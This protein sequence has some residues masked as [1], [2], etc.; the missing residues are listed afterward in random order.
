M[1][2]LIVDNSCQC[3]SQTIKTAN[4]RYNLVTISNYHCIK[5]K[6]SYFFIWKVFMLRANYFCSIQKFYTVITTESIVT[7]TLELVERNILLFK[8][9]CWEK[10]TIVS[11]NILLGILGHIIQ[12]FILRCRLDCVS[13]IKGIF[14]VQ[15][16]K[17][18]WVKDIFFQMIVVGQDNDS[19]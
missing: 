13:S 9:D 11:W 6:N 18:V 19:M 16:I 2:S 10:F 7:N 17:F 12:L 15:G 5:S 8:N 1:F 3:Y 4:W 14:K